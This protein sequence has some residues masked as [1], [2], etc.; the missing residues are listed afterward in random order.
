MRGSKGPPHRRRG[1]IQLIAKR[2]SPHL[3]TA[4]NS[5]QSDAGTTFSRF[6]IGLPQ[7]AAP[8]YS[9]CSPSRHSLLRSVA[10]ES[11]RK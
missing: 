5:D 8:H 6:L 2:K 11:K 9:A 3:L 10:L 4:N 1:E 7:N